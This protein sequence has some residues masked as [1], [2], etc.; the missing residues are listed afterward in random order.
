MDIPQSK[1]ARG[2]RLLRL[3]ADVAVKEVGARLPGKALEAA[4]KLNLRIEQTRLLVETLSQMKG[5][6]MKA[7][8]LLGLEG[9]D[10]F[11]P[12]VV[13]ILSRLQSDGD[14]LATPEIE[15]LLLAAW[16]EERFKQFGQLSPGPLASASIGQVHTGMWQGRKIAVK[17]QFPGVAQTID[18]DV[19]LLK[20]LVEKFLTI[21]R[22]KTE[23]G[24][25]FEE[26]RQTLHQETDYLAEARFMQQYRDN[27]EQLGGYLVPAPVMELC[28]PGVL[29][30]DYQAG[31]KIKDWV[32]Y[33]STDEK[34][35]LGERMM[36]LFLHEYLACG[37]VQTDPNW[38][39]FLVAPSGELVVLDFGACKTY[40]QEFRTTYRQVLSHSMHRRKHELITVSQSFGLLDPREETEAQEAYLHM[41]DV[42]I[43]PFRHVG[44]FDFATE[45]YSQN[46]KEA[47]LAFAKALKFS[48]PPRDLIFLHRKLGGVFQ[49]LKRMETKLDLRLVWEKMMLEST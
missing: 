41:M 38:G 17:V 4:Q 10:L 20:G 46:S 30:M 9:N 35:L 34:Q 29:A 18:S 49:T 27:F 15:R 14:P 48:P 31:Q 3:A 28:T 5:A 2:S 22:K 37:L 11:P 13:E 21:T 32:K 6:A 8:Q 33:A 25:L 40:S 39:N 42:V 26:I 43:A 16:G 47:S 45:T 7:G 36:S 24:A 1:W 23:L 19:A 12:E 44:M